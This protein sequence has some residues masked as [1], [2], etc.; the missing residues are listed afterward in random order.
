MCGR[1]INPTWGGQAGGRKQRL[2]AVRG[3]SPQPGPHQF[4]EAA[5]QRRAITPGVLLYGSPQLERVERIAARKFV[6]PTHFRACEGPAESLGQNGVHAPP[7]STDARGFVARFRAAATP[8]MIRVLVLRRVA[9]GGEHTDWPGEP[10][11]AAEMIILLGGS[12]H[13]RS[14]IAIST[15]DSCGEPSDDGYET[16]APTA[17]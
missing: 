7:G 11:R 2:A 9:H 14:S 5:R 6:Y 16:A 1:A 12:I 10:P 3:Q 13:W 8:A 15:G 17:R 4:R